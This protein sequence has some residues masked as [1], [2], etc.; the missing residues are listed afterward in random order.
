MRSVYFKSESDRPLFTDASLDFVFS[1]FIRSPNLPLGE[2]RELLYI[3]PHVQ[4][5]KIFTDNLRERF[6]KTQILTPD[7]IYTI[8]NNIR[9]LT[10]TSLTIPGPKNARHARFLNVPGSPDCG[11]D[12]DVPVR[13]YIPFG[14]QRGLRSQL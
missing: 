9:R 10:K 6:E 8:H 12:C 4:H 13:L 7:K 2:E 14:A 11:S 5:E 1:K 3:D